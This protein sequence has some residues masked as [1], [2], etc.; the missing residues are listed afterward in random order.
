M[1]AGNTVRGIDPVTLR[2]PA[3]GAAGVELDIAALVEQEQVE[4]ARSG[5]R[6]GTAAAGRLFGELVDQLGSGGVTGTA[7]SAGQIT[8]V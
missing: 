7:D 3:F 1:T 8:Y 4:A 5:P 2:P 6:R